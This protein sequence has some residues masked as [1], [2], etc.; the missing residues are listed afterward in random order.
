MHTRITALIALASLLCSSLAIAAPTRLN[1]QGRLLDGDGAPLTGSH[2]LAFTLHDA[3]TDGNEVWREERVVE[4]EEGYY[5]LVLGEF[6]PLSDLVFAGDSVWLQL[7]VD[8]AVLSPRHDVVSVPYALRAAVAEAVEGGSVDAD[9][10]SI[11]GD[12]VIDS[13]GNWLGTPPDWSELAGVPPDLADGDGDTLLGLPCIDGQVPT[14]DDSS[15]LWV[16]AAPSGIDTLAQLSCLGGELV[17][18]DDSNS[19]WVC[20]PDLDTQLTEAQVDAFVANNDYATGPH[21]TDTDTL[22]GLPCADGFVAK[23][24][25]VLG[26]WDCAADDDSLAELSCQSGDIPVYEALSGLWVCG[27]D[28]DTDTQLSETQVDAFVADNG[29]STGAHTSSLPWGSI[30][31]IPTDLAD[32]DQ[33]TQLTSVPWTML[34]GIPTDLADGDQDTQLTEPQVDAFVANNGYSTGGNATGFTSVAVG[35]TLAM[36]TST[37]D[38]A[39]HIAAWVDDGAGNTIPV[40]ASPFVECSV[41]G[42]GSGGSWSLNNVPSATLPAGEYNFTD[43]TLNAGTTLTF[44]GSV[45]VVL[46]VTGDVTIDGVI[47]LAGGN[48][49]GSTGGQGGPGGGNGGG[50]SANYTVGAGGVANSAW[51]GLD[52]TSTSNFGGGAARR[53]GGRRRTGHFC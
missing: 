5:S 2:G 22:V 51:A 25:V 30:T 29:Y 27:A 43:F 12:V 36:S 49:S 47:E 20:S 19:Q 28:L 23:Y 48:H 37:G 8:G 39:A 21:T 40:T 17:T 1:Q 50:G 24:S 46:R 34:T 11:G 18:W 53:G 42:D 9:E 45:P 15:A 33:D 31:G 16:C 14:Y 4:F 52:N 10:V 3:E 26:A 6:V 32:G 41:C 44:T 38:I 13:N 35:G 7:A